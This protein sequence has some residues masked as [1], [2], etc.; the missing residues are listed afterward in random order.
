MFEDQ[1]VA[2]LS[3]AP[4]GSANPDAVRVQVRLPWYRSLPLAC[5][6]RL[7]LALDGVPIPA[8]EVTIVMNG[9]RYP[10]ADIAEL[11]EVWWFVLDVL[12]LEIAPSRDIQPGDH[13]VDVALGLLLPYGDGDWR[14]SL[15]IRQLAEDSRQLTLEGRGTTA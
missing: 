9:A 7:D 3:R 8:A 2:G 13:L 6:E 4:V 1:V 5:V 11:R 15:N 12:D 14:A 10:L